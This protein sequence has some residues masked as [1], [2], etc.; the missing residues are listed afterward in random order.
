MGNRA[1]LLSLPFAPLAFGERP[2]SGAVAF[3]KY[4]IPFFWASLFDAQS[5]VRP[6]SG[7][8]FGLAAPRIDALSRSERRLRHCAEYFGWYSWPAAERWVEFL[9]S[10]EQP[11]IAVDVHDIDHGV[12]E[13]AEVLRRAALPGDDLVFADYFGR[14]D[15]RRPSDDAALLAGVDHEDYAPPRPLSKLHSAAPPSSGSHESAHA[16]QFVWR[17]AIE[18]LLADSDP[19]AWSRWFPGARPSSFRNDVA[20]VAPGTFVWFDPRV[21]A[22]MVIIASC[23]SAAMRVLGMPVVGHGFPP[24]ARGA[25][26]AAQM[27]D[28]SMVTVMGEY[29]VVLSSRRV[30]CSSMLRRQA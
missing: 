11:W 17:D 19:A 1:Y 20:V 21:Q 22:W 13:L 6:E 8:I 14:F 28:P 16:P 15:R 26:L 3:A 30:A 7:S 10:L 12:R 9:L 25:M 4:S 29:A 24:L 27:F 23:E 5:I 2:A 18:G